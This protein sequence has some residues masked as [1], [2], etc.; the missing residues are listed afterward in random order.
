MSES[1]TAG[2]LGG[3]PATSGVYT[4]A[5]VDEIVSGVIAGIDAAFSGFSVAEVNA[6]L[7]GVNEF[8][9]SAVP[10]GVSGSKYAYAGGMVSGAVS[11]VAANAVQISGISGSLDGLV[12]A[13]TEDD[14]DENSGS[15]IDGDG[16]KSLLLNKDGASVTNVRFNDGTNWHTV[17]MDDSFSGMTFADVNER[18]SGIGSFVDRVTCGYSGYDKYYDAGTMLKGAY[19][20]TYR[21]MS[22]LIGSGQSLYSGYDTWLSGMLASLMSGYM[23]GYDP[24]DS[25][26]R[27]GVFPVV[28][29]GGN[30][31]YEFCQAVYQCLSG[32]GVVTENNICTLVSGCISVDLGEIAGAVSGLK[33]ATSGL[34]FKLSEFLGNVV[35]KVI[36][37]LEN[38]INPQDLN[39]DAQQR[40]ANIQNNLDSDQRGQFVKRAEDS[41]NATASGMLPNVQ[42]ALVGDSSNP[43][44]QDFADDLA[45]A[46]SGLTDNTPAESQELSEKATDESASIGTLITDI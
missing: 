10:S 9:G 27:P 17:L 42:D 28:Y 29:D 16:E 6:T 11:G 43:G 25:G 1:V 18:L 15:G 22:I 21:M 5:Q 46:A 31:S 7:S 45:D 41:R 30:P 12:Y 20:D 34:T 13:E 33:D 35:D 8:I 4:A 40:L 36:Y 26:F 3:I 44:I 2:P 24:S 23:A 37:A 39:A 38:S 14:M 32:Q 19:D